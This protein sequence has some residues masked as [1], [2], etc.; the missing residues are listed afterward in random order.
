MSSE[1]LKCL[2]NSEQCVPLQQAWSTLCFR[3]NQWLVV[4]EILGAGGGRVRECSFRSV[5]LGSRNAPS[6]GRTVLCYSKTRNLDLW[7]SRGLRRG[8][9][10]RPGNYWL[11]AG[12][13]ITQ[14]SWLQVFHLCTKDAYFK[15][16]LYKLGSHCKRGINSAD[17]KHASCVDSLL[18]HW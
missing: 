18:S 5:W 7:K 14:L 1:T 17:I 2:S 13:E 10:S 4:R 12:A 16:S 6:V 3:G 15:V 8:S 9:P 11:L